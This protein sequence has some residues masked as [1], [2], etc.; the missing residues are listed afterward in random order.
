MVFQ[1]L[2]TEHLE[3]R[4]VVGFS[5]GEKVVNIVRF[6]ESAEHVSAHSPQFWQE[7]LVS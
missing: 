7:E 1:V 5:N 4:G 6:D 3:L 2:L